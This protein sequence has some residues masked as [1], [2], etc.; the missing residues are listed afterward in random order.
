MLFVEHFNNSVQIIYDAISGVR[1]AHGPT[2]TDKSAE[3]NHVM[4]WIHFV[5]SLINNCDK[6]KPRKPSTALVSICFSPQVQGRWFASIQLV[7]KNL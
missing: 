2:F 6:Y 4:M 5:V 1:K 7:Y 3:M